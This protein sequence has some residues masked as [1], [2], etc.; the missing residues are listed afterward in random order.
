MFNSNIL[1]L[2]KRNGMF[3][4]KKM[5]G[6]S[7]APCIPSHLPPRLAHMRLRLSMAL[8]GLHLGKTF[9]K[10]KVY[11][12]IHPAGRMC[13]GTGFIELYKPSQL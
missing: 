5:I 2:Y 6:N 8:G 9:C 12:S 11:R 13:P 7:P 10:R 3:L 4:L 1:R